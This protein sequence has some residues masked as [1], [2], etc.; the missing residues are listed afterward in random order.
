MKHGI[1]YFQDILLLIKSILKG[2]CDEIIK[3]EILGIL[4]I[5]SRDNEPHISFQDVN[6][7]IIKQLREAK[8][9]LSSISYYGIIERLKFETNLIKLKKG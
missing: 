9:N 1:D 5:L 7:K 2:E 8:Q 4:Q 6:Y 3:L